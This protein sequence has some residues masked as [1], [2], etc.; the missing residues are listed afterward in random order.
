MNACLMRQRGSALLPGVMIILALAL[1][2]LGAQLPRDAHLRRQA[3]YERHG[4][5]ARHLAQS[6]LEKGAQ[7]AWTPGNGWQ[8]RPETSPARLCVR[9]SA[10]KGLILMRAHS[11]PFTFGPQITLFRYL[12]LQEGELSPLA[13]GRI[14]YCPEPQEALC[15]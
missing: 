9:L 1:M 7:M 15:Q 8:C 12:V 3:L 5:I 11:A 6:A 2:M 10:R 14:D 4:L 13:H